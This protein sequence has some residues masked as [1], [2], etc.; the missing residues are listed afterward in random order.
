[1]FYLDKAVNK[2]FICRVQSVAELTTF[3]NN[4]IK[5]IIS[6][7]KI[8]T[9]RKVVLKILSSLINISYDSSKTSNYIALRTLTSSLLSNITSH[10]LDYIFSKKKVNDMEDTEDG[11][12]LCVAKFFIMCSFFHS[13]PI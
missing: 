5:L 6:N 10:V 1:M 13:L 3:Q 4:L 8:D 11:M 2:T 9:N 12:Y 7:D